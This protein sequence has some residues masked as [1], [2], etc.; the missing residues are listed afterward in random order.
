MLPDRAQHGMQPV[1]PRRAE[2]LS[3]ADLVDESVAGIQDR[4]R[5]EPGIRSEQDRDEAADNRGIADSLEVQQAIATLR[6][7][8]DLCLAALDLVLVGLKLRREF[9]E[10]APKVD[11]VLIAVHPVIEEFELVDDFLMYGLD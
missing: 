11:D 6:A 4:L 9:R 2:M 10:L 1:A 5:R 8:P 3:K 7:E